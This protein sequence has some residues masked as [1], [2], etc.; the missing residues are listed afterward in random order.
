M[1]SITGGT[2]KYI[3]QPALIEKH[4][5]TLEWLAETIIWKAELKVVQKKL[6]EVSLDAVQISDKKKLDHF[7]NLVIYYNGEVVVEIR[8]K[9]RAHEDKLARML[10]INAE[11]NIEY[12]REH[13]IVMGNAEAVRVRLMEVRTELLAWI[14]KLKGK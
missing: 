11:W 7:Q 2:N 8:K 14:H 4:R 9:L 3:L 1:V 5:K 13:N 6:D 10:E 12:F